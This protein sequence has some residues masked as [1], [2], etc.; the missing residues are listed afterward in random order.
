MKNRFHGVFA[1]ILMF[2]ALSVADYVILKNNIIFGVIYAALIP[3]MFF[4]IVN[5]FCRKC[6]HL[7]DDSCRH[8][9][10]GKIANFLGRKNIEKYV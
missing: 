10:F 7:L 5:F 9:I 6:H 4:I 2:C 3:I 1:L 8:V